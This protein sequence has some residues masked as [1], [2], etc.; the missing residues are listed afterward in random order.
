MLANLVSVTDRGVAALSRGLEIVGRAVLAFMALTIGYDALMRY[1]FAAPTSWSLE[2]NSFLVVYLAVMVA[3]DVERRG[4]HIGITLLPDRLGRRGARVLGIIVS[5]VGVV[6]C[7]I[8]TW[9]GAMMSYE[10]WSYEERVSSAFGTPI[11]LPYAMLPVG[12]GVLSLQF[13]LN[14]FKGRPAAATAGHEIA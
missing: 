10:A 8:L 1:F 4:E 9:R 7:A 14:L 2:I 3:A 11:W 13:L 6:F 5:V 12:F